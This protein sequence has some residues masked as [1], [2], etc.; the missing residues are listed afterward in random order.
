MTVQ[1]PEPFKATED[2]NR[3]MLGDEIVPVQVNR[4]RW[5]CMKHSWCHETSAMPHH[6]WLR[7]V[8]G[9]SVET[10]EYDYTNWIPPPTDCSQVL[11]AV[12]ATSLSSL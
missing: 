1:Y 12:L 3:L 4:R 11:K 8:I 5:L 10:E 9:Y 2:G 6:V 7:C